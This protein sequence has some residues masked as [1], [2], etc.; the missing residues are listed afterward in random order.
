MWTDPNSLCLHTVFVGYA[1]FPTCKLEHH[2]S[3][4]SHHS[5][6]CWEVGC[7]IFGPATYNHTSIVSRYTQLTGRVWPLQS[8]KRHPKCFTTTAR[9][10][11]ALITTPLSVKTCSSN[12]LA[13]GWQETN[14]GV[15]IQQRSQ[16]WG[17]MQ[18][19]RNAN[20]TRL[21]YKFW[22]GWELAETT[23]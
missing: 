5:K 1:L 4:L 3:S 2:I 6:T 10:L 7:I 14:G 11:K 20:P 21:T 18:T 15:R 16:R 17:P 12:S 23:V 13:E 8:A 22:K 19:T 9:S